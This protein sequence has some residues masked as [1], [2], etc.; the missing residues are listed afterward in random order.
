MEVIKLKNIN[1]AYPGEI[2]VFTGLNFSLR[3]GQRA[4]I[5]GANGSGQDN[6]FFFN[7]GIGRSS[8]RHYFSF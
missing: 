4:G 2:E 3:K 6:P 8:K 7:Y 1:Y 5:I